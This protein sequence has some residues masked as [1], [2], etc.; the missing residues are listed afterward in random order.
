MWGSTREQLDALVTEVNTGAAAVAQL[1]QNIVAARNAGVPVNE[2]ADQRDKLVLH[3]SEVTGAT[4]VSRDDG[5]VDL[6]LGGSSLVN[7]P[8]ARTIKATGATRFDDQAATP[9]GLVWTDTNTGA[10]AGG[11][12]LSSVLETLG[13]TLPTYSASLDSVAASLVN[14]VNTQHKAGY[15]L[16]G[17]AGGDF[18][19]PTG[20][21][22]GTIAIAITDPSKLAAAGSP[23]GSLDASNADALA[24]LADSTTGPDR[25]YRQFVVD[26]GVATQTIDRRTGIQAAVMQDVDSSRQAES[27]VNLDEEMTNMITYQRAYEAAS[28]VMTAVDTILDTLINKTGLVGR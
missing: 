3:L 25:T 7:G 8:N 10:I 22:A 9:V 17:T 20:T 18:F 19:T 21:T 27:G 5:S 15:D 11:G 13:K 12:E 4:A 1:N 28:R 2:L 16:A 23:G 26:L 24:G 14:A 6:Q